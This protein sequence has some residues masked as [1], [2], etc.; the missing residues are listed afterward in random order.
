MKTF[1]PKMLTQMGGGSRWT[2]LVKVRLVAGLPNVFAALKLAA[3]AAFLGAVLAFFCVLG[4][5]K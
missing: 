1:T 4:A 3:P 5:T 2:Q